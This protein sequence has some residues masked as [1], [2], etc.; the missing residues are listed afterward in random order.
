MISNDSASTLQSPGERMEPY[1]GRGSSDADRG[2]QIVRA[3]FARFDLV[4]LAVATGCVCGLGLWAATVVLLLKGAPPGVSVGPHL[5]LLAHFLPG[6]TVSWTG[7]YLALFYGF[8]IG[9]AL[10]GFVAGVWNIV[11]HAYLVFAV[12][13]RYFAGDL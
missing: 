5:A 1:H 13:R 7:S 3:A 6:Y 4:A 2:E 11:H 9:V 10:G 12:T 8:L